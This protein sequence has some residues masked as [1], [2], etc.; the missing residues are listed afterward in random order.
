ME[1]CLIV[2]YDCCSK[3]A[4]TLL[5]SR[6]ED[7]HVRVLNTIHGDQ[8]FGVYHYLTGGATV[9]D[10][11]LTDVLAELLLKT[12]WGH[13]YMCTNPMKNITLDGV[14]NGCDGECHNYDNF[15]ADDLI[16]KVITEMEKVKQ[17]QRSDVDAESINRQN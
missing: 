16:K 6:K 9:T 8:A 14:N 5:V 15:T 10:Y 11:N 13:C 1:D 17:Q 4:T 7:N 3:D 12:D 2:T